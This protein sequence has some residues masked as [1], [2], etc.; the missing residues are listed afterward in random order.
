M[1]T[2]MQLMIEDLELKYKIL[3]DAKMIQGCAAL[4]GS[5]NYA[6]SL[7]LNEVNQTLAAYNNGSQDMALH[8]KYEPME[9][10]NQ[11]YNQN[12]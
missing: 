11:T 3:S 9:Y 1:K 8:N 5:I 4:E 12:K 2:A 7:L 6:K 10:Y